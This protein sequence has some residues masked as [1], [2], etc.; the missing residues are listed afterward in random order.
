VIAGGVVPA[1]VGALVGVLAGASATAYWGIG[2]LAG[3]GAFLGGFE[4][5][6]GWGAAD[7]GF[8]GGAIYG[9]A[10][11]IARVVIGNPSKV[12]LGSAPVLLAL[13]TA[14]IGMLLSAAGGSI[15]R[16]RRQ[17]AAAARREIDPSVRRGG[18]EVAQPQRD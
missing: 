8:V 5:Q 1:A 18:S 12:S 2:A 3:L 10:L 11:L 14:I 4:H 6:D 16:I 17:H 9:S 7:R 15:A 13:V